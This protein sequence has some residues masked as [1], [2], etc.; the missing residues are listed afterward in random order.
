VAVP[1][2]VVVDGNGGMIFGECRPAQIE[3]IAS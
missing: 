2:A 1:S 3:E